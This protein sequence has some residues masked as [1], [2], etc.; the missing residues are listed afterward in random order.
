MREPSIGV[1]VRI[2]ESKYERVAQRARSQGIPVVASYAR[3]LLL[4]DAGSMSADSPLACEL[5]RTRSAL[6][7]AIAQQEDLRPAIL[8]IARI[9]NEIQTR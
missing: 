9:I 4:E 2:P 6:V 1:F 3:A 7:D 5:A 8:S